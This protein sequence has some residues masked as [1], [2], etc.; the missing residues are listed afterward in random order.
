[1]FYPMPNQT[2]LATA[3]APTGRSCRSSATRDRADG[4]IDHELTSNDSLFGARQLAAPRPGRVHLREHR[5]QR[6][7]RPHQS[8]HPRPRVEGHRR[9]PPAGRASSRTRIVNE[10]RGGYSEDVRNRRSQYIAGEV[11]AAVGIEVPALAAERPRLPAVHLRRREPPVGHPRPAAEHVPRP[12]PGVVLDQQQH[13]VG[14]GPP[15]GA[16]S[17]ASTRATSR[18]TAT[19]PAPT[20]RRA[21]TTS[22]AGPPATPSPTSCSACPTPCASSATRA[23]TSRW[24]RSPTTGRCSCR[25]T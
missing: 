14:E 24:T 20:S 16:R 13:D 5:R 2:A 23:A 12:R 4:R 1:M 3:T 22:A 21:S 18:R 6:R 10:L 11:G 25:T 9:S 17:A 19:R 8:R 7:R 15:L